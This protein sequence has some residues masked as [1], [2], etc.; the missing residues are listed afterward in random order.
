MVRE[1]L[2]AL[3]VADFVSGTLGALILVR[4]RLWSFSFRDRQS[5]TDFTRAQNLTRR[6]VYS[7]VFASPCVRSK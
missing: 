7:G 3:A 6:R 1:A 2:T 5:I 4:M